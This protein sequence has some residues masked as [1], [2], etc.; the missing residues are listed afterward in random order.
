[1]KLKL[2]FIPDEDSENP[3]KVTGENPAE[4]IG[5]LLMA[6]QEKY[7]LQP[8]SINPILTA[9]SKIEWETG[10]GEVREWDF[11]CPE[12]AFTIWLIRD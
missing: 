5:A 7:N 10:E 2:K 11:S 8:E 1:M 6:L 3:T 4:V 9:L 12:D